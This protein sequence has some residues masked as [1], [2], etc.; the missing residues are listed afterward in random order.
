MFQTHEPDPVAEEAAYS[1]QIGR[2]LD[3][4]DSWMTVDQFLDWCEENQLDP[5]DPDV[6]DA[7]EE[8]ASDIYDSLLSYRSDY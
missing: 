3:F 2:R 1:D 5:D 4:I 8:E 6:I 7:G